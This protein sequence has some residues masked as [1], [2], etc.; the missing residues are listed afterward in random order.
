MIDNSSYSICY[1]DKSYVPP[2][3]NI[4]RDFFWIETIDECFRLIY[5]AILN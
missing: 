1:Y 4:K 3:E 2:R 5:D